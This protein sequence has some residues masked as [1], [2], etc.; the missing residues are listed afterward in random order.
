MAKDESTLRP[1]RAQSYGTARCGPACRVVWQGR[2]G[3]RSP[4]ADFCAR[5]LA[6]AFAIADDDELLKKNSLVSLSSPPKH[7]NVI[8]LSLRGEGAA[9]RDLLCANLYLVIPNAVCGV[10]NL[11][12]PFANPLL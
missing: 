4:Y 5:W 8:R 2:A 1:A 9:A 3:D 12:S 6:T 11:S 7:A 10:R